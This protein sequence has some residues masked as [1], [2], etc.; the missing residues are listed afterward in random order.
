M[1]ITSQYVAVGGDLCNLVGA[2][3]LTYDL[4]SRPV[5]EGSKHAAL[6]FRQHAKH[7]AGIRFPGVPTSIDVGP[8][9][10]PTH[11]IERLHLVTI[12]RL[13][14]LGV[15]LLLIGFGL[16]LAS[17]ITEVLNTPPVHQSNGQLTGAVLEKRIR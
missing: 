13:A 11:Q 14:K 16:S 7:S 15:G 2:L 1:H 12:S 5:V 10:D 8:N 6:L 4:F 17:H 3:L 9:T